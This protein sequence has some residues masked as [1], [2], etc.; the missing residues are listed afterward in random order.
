M[1]LDENTAQE[2]QDRGWQYVGVCGV[3]PGAKMLRYKNSSMSAY[4]VR[5]SKNTRLYALRKH[6][7]ML[8]KRLQLNEL[9]DILD[10]LC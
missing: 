10:N 5:Y 7:I 1:T 4:E 9:T 8:Y 6:G 2:L 3:C